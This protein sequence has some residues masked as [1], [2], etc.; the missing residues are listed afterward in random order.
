[1]TMITGDE[2]TT[3]TDKTVSLLAANVF[4]TL[5]GLLP[6]AALFLAFSA[7]WRGRVVQPPPE[8]FSWLHLLGLFVAGILV[9]ELLHGLGW[10]LFGGVARADI[11]LGVKW[12]LLTPYAHTSA[13]VAVW[14]YR[15]AVLLPGLVLGV[16]P[17]LAGIATG[18]VLLLGFGVWFT[19]TAGGDFLVLWLLRDVPA[20]A[21]VADH[22][23][24]AGSIVYE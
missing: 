9:H 20:D 23:T 22:P 24:K 5:F 15:W 8:W 2:E 7:V 14:P 12:K 6:A 4:G 17:A 1:M 19:L 18:S 16:L 13:R 3:G 11:Q 10:M 21:E